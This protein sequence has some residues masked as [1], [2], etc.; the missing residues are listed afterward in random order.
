[1]LTKMTVEKILIKIPN[2]PL[3]SLASGCTSSERAQVDSVKNESKI[4]SPEP[5]DEGSP[6]NETPVDSPS[7]EAE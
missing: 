4:S 1:M 7:H 3:Q 6:G 5:T 2:P